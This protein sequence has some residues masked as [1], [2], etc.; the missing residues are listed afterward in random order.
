VSP[1]VIERL[2]SAIEGR[3]SD[4]VLLERWRVR[5]VKATEWVRVGRGPWN[6]A[7]EMTRKWQ[8]V[9]ERVDLSS[10]IVPYALRHSSIVRGLTHDLPIR[11]V[12]ALHDTSVAMI[13][14]YYSRWITDISRISLRRRSYR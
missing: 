8:T 10:D 9:R 5:Q 4:E 3:A 2:A 6:A 7:S 14:R 12:A 13:E 11:L 1:N